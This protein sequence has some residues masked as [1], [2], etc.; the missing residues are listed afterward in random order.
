MAGLDP[1]AAPTA[2]LGGPT[3]ATSLPRRSRWSLLR[4]IP[5][6]YFGSFA[7]IGLACAIFEVG[8][9]GWALISHPDAV[10]LAPRWLVRHLI[11]IPGMAIL[12]IAGYVTMRAWYDARWWRALLLSVLFFAMIATGALISNFFQLG[13]AALRSD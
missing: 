2:P 4:Y 9:L 7:A 13:S 12:G 11:R 5:V 3:M 10:L 6:V 8:F 1:Y